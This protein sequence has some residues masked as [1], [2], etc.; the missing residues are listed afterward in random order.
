MACLGQ[1]NNSI[2]SSPET[3]FVTSTSIQKR[4]NQSDCAINTVKRRKLEDGST[5]TTQD[6]QTL[7]ELKISDTSSPPQTYSKSD[8]QNKDC[9]TPASKKLVPSSSSGSLMNM[10]EHSVDIPVNEKKDDTLVTPQ[11][12]LASECK[13]EWSSAEIAPGGGARVKPVVGGIYIHYAEVEGER[14]IP[15]KCKVLQVDP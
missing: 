14:K 3:L 10:K 11:R 12:F 8:I 5:N 4:K 9:S 2:S 13:K 7:K 1:V 6:S 15:V